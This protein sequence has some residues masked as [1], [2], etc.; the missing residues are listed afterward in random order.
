MEEMPLIVSDQVVLSQAQK[1]IIWRTANVDK[2]KKNA[3]K[4]KAKK[5]ENSVKLQIAKCQQKLTAL[6]EKEAQKT[7]TIPILA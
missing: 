1:Y 5:K 2:Y 3:E 6:I 4:Q 7:S